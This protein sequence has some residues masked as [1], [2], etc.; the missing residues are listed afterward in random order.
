MNVVEPQTIPG[1]VDPLEQRT[2]FEIARR[3]TF[4]TGESVVEFGT[5]FGRSTCCIVNGLL[6]QG[7]SDGA[8]VSV[9]AYDSFSCAIQ[10]SFYRHVQRDAAENSLEPLLR[11]EAD[12]VR[13]RGVFDHYLG[14]YQASGLLR[15][16]EG[17]LKDCASGSSRI[18]MMHIDCP[19]FYKELKLILVRFFPH[20]QRGALVIFQDFFYQWSATLIAAVQLLAERGIVKFLFSAACS[21]VVEVVERPS[22]EQI[23]RFDLAMEYADVAALIDRAIVATRSIVID[24]PGRFVPRL[25]LAKLQ[26]MFESGRHHEAAAALRGALDGAGGPIDA[27]LFDDLGELVGMGFD[28]RSV[29]EIDHAQRSPA[30]SAAA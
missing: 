23:S 9:H 6:A 21:L 14:E 11:F 19:K 8:R 26:Y 20:L 17:E 24:R 3:L 1:M 7:I 2:L 30:A 29:Y 15:A 4:E 28:L 18:R 13:F 16:V 10:G 5:Y 25:S 22:A 12:R 27:L